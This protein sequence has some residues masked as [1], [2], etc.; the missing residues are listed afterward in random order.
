VGGLGTLGRLFTTGAYWLTGD[1]SGAMVG[2][3]VPD[4]V[5]RP[6]MPSRDCPSSMVM[7]G[8]ER[9]PPSVGPA[10]RRPAS[11]PP[12]HLELT[13][14]PSCERFNTVRWRLVAD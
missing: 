14:A 5:R 11:L 3:A 1:L 8:T 12:P 4:S 9:D 2:N 6:A 10:G 7:F 13:L